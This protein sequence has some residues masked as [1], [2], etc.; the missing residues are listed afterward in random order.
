MNS[1]IITII[2]KN[3][4]TT[5]AILRE[6]NKILRLHF[7]TMGFKRIDSR[8]TP[9]GFFIIKVEA[10]ALTGMDGKPKD[11]GYFLRVLSNAK[12]YATK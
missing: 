10:P 11:R 6:A 5:E 1:I 9:Q 4:T 12:M 8:R 3:S 2:D 7:N